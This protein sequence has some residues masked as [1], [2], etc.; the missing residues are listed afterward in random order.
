MTTHILITGASR[1]IGAA[2]ADALARPD[3]RT[4]ALSSADGDLGDPA[5]PDRLW[6]ESLVRLD[7]RIDVLINHAGVFE[8]N[9]NETADADWLSG[10]ERTLDINLTADVLLCQSAVPRWGVGRSA[11]RRVGRTGAR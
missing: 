11:K 8:A 9:P 10:W 3:C 5:V 6:A 2:I 7:G 1:G 4:V